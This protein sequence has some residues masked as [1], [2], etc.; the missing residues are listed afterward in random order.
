MIGRAGEFCT[1]RRRRTLDAVELAE[2]SDLRTRT[3]RSPAGGVLFAAERGNPAAETIVLVHGYPDTHGCW[4]ELADV[5][6]RRLHV[7]AFDVRGM[8]AS[9]LPDGARPYRLESLR[10]DLEAVIDAVS[11]N[12]PVH[13]VGHDWGAIQCWSALSGASLDGRVA[14]FTS[15]AGS[16][17]DA[18]GGWARRRLR[19]GTKAFGELLRQ[20]AHSW[21]IGCL[22]VPRLPEMVLRARAAHDWPVWL[23]RLEGI[24]P[25]RGHPAASLVDDAVRGIGLYR[26]NVGRS[27]P[28]RPGP[29]R[30]PVLLV[31]PLRDRYL[32]PALYDGA[33]AWARDLRRLE[34]ATGHWAQ[35]T[36]PEEIGAA[37]LALV[38][39]DYMRRPPATGLSAAASPARS[40][41]A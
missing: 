15:I 24:E 32:T 33:E 22:M 3:I 28:G 9:T 8:G 38:V 31:I 14:S 21:Y 17:L 39:A 40:T 13:L 16:R 4:D 30:V 19:P 26:E 11:P 6:S 35:R 2:V 23:R 7:V 29:I 10:T 27:G 41:E 20:L 12:A 37:V 18:V 36:H 5:L 1:C 25:R 34:L